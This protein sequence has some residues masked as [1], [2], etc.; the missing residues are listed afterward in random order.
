MFIPPSETV[1]KGFAAAFTTRRSE[2]ISQALRLGKRFELLEGVVLD[3]ADALAG[4]AE[5]STDLLERPRPPPGEPEA[6][7]DHLALA[8]WQRVECTL[9]VLAAEGQRGRV[10]RG[11]GLLVGDEVAELGLL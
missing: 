5:R 1:F 10:E 9:D 4:D 11:L 8:I 7:L 6:E 2:A 3:L